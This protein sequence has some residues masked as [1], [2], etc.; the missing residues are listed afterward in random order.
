MILPALLLP[1]LMAAAPPTVIKDPAAKTM[2]M[3]EHGFTVQWV[4]WGRDKGKA[5]VTEQDGVLRL[6]GEQ[7]HGS[8]GNWATIDGIITE[9][10]GKH[11]RFKGR[12]EIR[13]DFL[14]GGKPCQREGE[15]T[16]R[17]SGARRFWRLKEMVNPCEDGNTVDY[18]DLH[19]R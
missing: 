6:K 19:F 16:F 1:V 4:Q 17:I 8:S 15:F 18:V 3:G 13:V 5:T 9:A 2:L 14:G 11:F 12:I 10:A 7:R